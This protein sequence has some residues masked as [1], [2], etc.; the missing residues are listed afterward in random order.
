MLIVP[1]TLSEQLNDLI[2]LGRKRIYIEAEKI[3]HLHIYIYI[4]IYIKKLREII[5]HRNKKAL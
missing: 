3:G 4:Y 1:F 5:R 2:F